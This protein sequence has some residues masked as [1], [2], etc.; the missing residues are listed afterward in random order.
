MVK[1]HHR[2]P[3]N[4]VIAPECSLRLEPAAMRR[5]TASI[6]AKAA[7]STE[8]SSIKHRLNA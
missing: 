5:I 3:Q 8:L 2:P 6:P 4:L 7:A 1:S